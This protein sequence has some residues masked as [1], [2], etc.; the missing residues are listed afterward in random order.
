[1]PLMSSSV[2]LPRSILHGWSW[3]LVIY[4][5]R[6]LLPILMSGGSHGVRPIFRPPR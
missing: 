6:L 3:F 5:A 2:P 1:M 4:S